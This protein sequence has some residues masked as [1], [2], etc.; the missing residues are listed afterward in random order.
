MIVRFFG[1]KNGGGVGSINYLLD[2]REK[3]GTARV[4]Q[5]DAKLTKNLIKSIDFKQKTCVGCLSF[6]EKNIDE[7]KKIEIMTDFEKALMTDEMKGRYNILWVEHT[8]KGRLELNFVIPKIDLESKTSLNPYY[9][10]QDYKRIKIWQDYTNLKHNFS[11]PNDPNKAQTIKGTQKETKLFKNYDEL[12]KILKDEAKQGNLKSR[13][14][15]IS[16]LKNANIEVTRQGKDYISVK[17]PDSK[18]AKRFK[19]SIYDERFTGITGLEAILREKERDRNEYLQSRNGETLRR[20][21]TDLQ[22]SIKLKSEQYREI[23]QR[24]DERS[25]KKYS[26]K[27]ALRNEAISNNFMLDSGISTINN[28]IS[29]DM[30][31]VDRTKTNSEQLESRTNQGRRQDFNFKK[32]SDNNI[33][34]R[35]REYS[36][37]TQIRKE[38]DSTRTELDGR[39]GI[40][41]RRARKTCER[42]RT[43]STGIQ[44]AKRNL[45]QS[46]DENHTIELKISIIDDRIRNIENGFKILREFIEQ[47]KKRLKKA[48]EKSIK[49][50][51]R[52]RDNGISMGW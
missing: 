47:T 49:K 30:V 1:V 36:N 18:K 45:R 37:Q 38:N 20:L 4:L 48:Y 19:R 11:D 44:R 28:D 10:K 2:K 21:N 12:D 22:N 24:R 52:K 25:R 5:G 40:I 27:T 16:F 15:I 33:Q 41:S 31:E 23:N 7:K 51:Q 6:E 35:Q 26:D 50:T 29:W 8:D 14:E 34:R 42:I 17:L 9:F 13:T 39:S 32:Q 3:I 46:R 43:T